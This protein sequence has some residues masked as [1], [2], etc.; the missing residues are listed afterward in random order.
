[1]LAEAREAD[2]RAHATLRDRGSARDAWPG[3]RL[4]GEPADAAHRNA[5]RCASRCCCARCGATPDRVW[6]KA[7]CATP[8]A[9][10]A[11][12]GLPRPTPARW[13]NAALAGGLPT[14]AQLLGDE[15]FAAWRARFWQPPRPGTGD[16]ATWGAMPARFI[17][18]SAQLADEP[19]LA[20]VAR[21]DWAGASGLR[22]ADDDRRRRPG[23][24][25]H[26]DPIRC[27]C[28]ACRVHA[29]LRS[30]H[31]VARDL[32][33][34]P[35]TGPDRF[36]PCATAFA[37]DRPKR[38]CVCAPGLRVR[39]R[40]HRAPMPPSC[41]RCCTPGRC[42]RADAAGS[43]FDIRGLADRRLAVAAWPPCMPTSPE[44]TA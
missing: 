32:A 11:A 16:L 19:Y 18:A 37:G 28:A 14:V 22:A 17:A 21:L 3:G 9:L 27:G 35:A 31:P 42:P 38:R 8:G 29:L 43:G 15:S 40:P 23:P 5:R 24:A 7:G 12:A 20:D 4:N 44:E 10:G 36:A 13:P 33:R 1:V 2:A 30:A 6:S 34:A 25:G 26:A 39:W 41:R